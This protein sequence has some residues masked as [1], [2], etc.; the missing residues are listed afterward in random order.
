MPRVYVLGVGS[1]QESDV[2]RHFESCG[3][4]EKIETRGH[5]AFL[6]FAE[7]A[8]AAKAVESMNNSE[9]NGK[10]LK[11]EPAS[12][13]NESRDGMAG[14]RARGNVVVRQEHRYRIENLNES[15]QWMDLKD[16]A[17]CEDKLSVTFAN[18]AMTNV[19]AVGI[20]EYGSQEDFDKAPSLLEG[21]TL[22]GSAVVMTRE[23]D[24]NGVA[25]PSLTIISGSRPQQFR[26][27]RPN[28]RGRG[29]YSRGSDYG[30][31]GG[32]YG[33]GGGDYG[34]GGGDY[35]RGGVDYGRGGG[36]YGR[37]GGDFDRGGGGYRDDYR[38]GGGDR[39]RDAPPPSSTYDRPR[40]A[41]S[42]S[43][44]RGGGA[45]A[46]PSSYDYRGPPPPRGRS[47]SR[48]RP[49]ERADS[50]DLGPVPRAAASASYGADAGPGGPRSYDAPP[51]RDY[52]GDRDRDSRGPPGGASSY[53]PLDRDS[54]DDRGGY[55]GG[56]GG[57]GYSGGGGG[58][59]RY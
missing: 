20:V 30:R 21:V 35:G 2:L 51:P 24:E 16:W 27:D 34:R 33:R 13:R 53:P 44:D 40:Y 31:G 6:Y 28:D 37:G 7:E 25:L 18:V 26:N 5:Y 57:G 14:T 9:L 52:R 10:T 58:G 19:G 4:I 54:R 22:K 32:D 50:R 15:T 59:Y 49:R 42:A 55:G 45:G 36:D 41:D 1:A 43:Y 48:E 38:G 56:G 46:G 29:P 11:V 47:R 8:D 17:R 3:R 23:L 12:A 39:Y